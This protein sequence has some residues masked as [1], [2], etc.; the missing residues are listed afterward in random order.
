MKSVQTFNIQISKKKTSLFVI[1]LI[2]I[3]LTLLLFKSTNDEVND[4]KKTI[5]TS[6]IKEFNSSLETLEK[7]LEDQQWETAC[8]Q[9][10]TAH[11]LIDIHFQEFNKQES[12]YDWDEMKKVLDIVPKQFCKS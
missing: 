7:L 1:G 3:S 4:Q 10:K 9:A 12:Y 2:T 8:K 5:S 11:D 6:K